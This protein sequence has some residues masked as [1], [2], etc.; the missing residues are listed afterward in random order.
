MGRTKRPVFRVACIL[1]ADYYL[2]TRMFPKGLP[3]I[4]L[5][6]IT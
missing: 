3:A 2:K 1:I 5:I 4:K 6:F